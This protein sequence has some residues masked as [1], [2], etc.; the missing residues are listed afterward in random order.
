M[1]ATKP[2]FNSQEIRIPI[3]EVID[4]IKNVRDEYAPEVLPETSALANDICGEI[5]GNVKVAAGLV[6]VTDS[7][8]IS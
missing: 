1:K 4:I 5:I 3:G 2:G 7:E 8:G 6:S